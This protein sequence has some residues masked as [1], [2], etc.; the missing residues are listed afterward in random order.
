[1]VKAIHNPIS[2]TVLAI[3]SNL[4]LILIDLEVGTL[5]FDVLYRVISEDF[6]FRVVDVAIT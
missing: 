3:A 6:K 2:D 1:L 5:D 4:S